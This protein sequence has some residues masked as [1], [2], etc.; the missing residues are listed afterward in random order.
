MKLDRITISDA[1][2]TDLEQV[3]NLVK[4]LALYEK[5][6]ASVTTDIDEYRKCFKEG[7]FEAVLAKLDD[8]IV[9]MALYYVTFSTWR[10]KMM[11]LEDFIVQEEY[12]KMGIGELLFDE[13]IK[14][15]KL[16]N[17]KM[18][19]WQVLDWNKPAVKFYEKKGATIEKNWWN[20]KII[21]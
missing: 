17:A 1:H 4:Q 7:V 8:E 19:K 9:G 21:F 18:V 2:E 15:S 10:G 20:G 13:Y 11:Y 5:E 16:K 14:I 6:P 3:F 12:R